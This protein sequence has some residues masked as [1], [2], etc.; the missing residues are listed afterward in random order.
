VVSIPFPYPRDTVVHIQPFANPS[1]ACFA[2]TT[3][4]FFALSL[5]IPY[6]AILSLS[7][8]SLRIWGQDQ[9]RIGH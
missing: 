4:C 8:L 2:S 7:A 6:V 1:Q 9:L 3:A 5:P